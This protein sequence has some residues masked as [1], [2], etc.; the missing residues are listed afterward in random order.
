MET[1]LLLLAD[2]KCSAH[3]ESILHTLRSIVAIT[4]QTALTVQSGRDFSTVG[5]GCKYCRDF[6]TV[7]AGCKY[8]REC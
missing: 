5:A 1:F 4:E 6:S 8:C 2:D 7:G 3:L